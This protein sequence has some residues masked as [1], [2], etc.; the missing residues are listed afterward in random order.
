MP[1][2]RLIRAGLVISPLKN[3]GCVKE[4]FLAG[5]CHFSVLLHTLGGNV[6]T[7]PRSNVSRF[8]KTTA[9]LLR[10]SGRWANPR[11]VK[12]ES[13]C[14]LLQL[15]YTFEFFFFQIRKS[16]KARVRVLS[17]WVPFSSTAVPPLV[18]PQG[19]RRPGSLMLGAHEQLRR[20]HQPEAPSCHRAGSARELHAASGYRW[21]IR[22][23]VLPS[24]AEGSHTHRFVI[25]QCRRSEA[26]QSRAGRAALLWGGILWG[27]PVSLPPPASGRPPLPSSPSAV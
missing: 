6:S 11:Q 23:P 22:F 21:V 14:L 27:E 12:A 19:C 18:P 2:F 17:R 9:R 24:P 13:L 4:W 8:G 5:L 26:L 3:V 20:S 25:F 10:Q 1:G 15:S 7:S 16:Q